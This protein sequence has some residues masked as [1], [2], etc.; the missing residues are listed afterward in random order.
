M[1]E[2]DELVVMECCNSAAAGLLSRLTVPVRH[3]SGPHAGKSAK[4][5]EAIR[6]A[7]GELILITD[8]DCRVPPDWVD[9]MAQPFAN[10]AVGVTFGPA[11]GISSAPGGSAG[12]VI[13]AGPA[14]PELW[15]YA[16]AAS[17][18]VRLLAVAD[19]GGF[20]ER[21]G[22]GSR[23]NGEEADL[24]LRLAAR[25]WTCEIAGSSFVQ[26]LERRSS[27]ETMRDLLVDRRG[28][29]TYLGAGLRR[30]PGRTM[31]P[32]I[33]RLRHEIGVWSDRRSHGLWLGPKILLALL[34]GLA[35]GAALPPQRF[36]DKPTAVLPGGDRPRVLWVTDEPPDRHL[37]GGNIRQAMLLAALHDRVDVT[38]LIVGHLRDEITRSALSEVIELARP[39][40]RPPPSIT[41]RRLRD[42]WQATAGR[43][44]SDVA[45]ARRLRRVLRP[46]LGRIADDFDVVVIQ[47]LYL[48]PLLPT[49]RRAQWLLH[50]FDVSSERTRHELADEGGCRQRWLLSREVAK[51]ARYER[52][53]VD[54]YDSV[55]VVS[56]Q[57][58]A[59]LAGNR[60]ANS[61]QLVIV[62]NG[63]DTSAF[64]PTPLP[65]EPRVLLPA[66]LSYRP[67][68][69]GARW[70]C[71]EVLPL[72]QSKVPEV[73]FNLVGRQPVPEVIALARRPGVELH[74][75]VPQ[76]APWLAQ[77]RVIVVP[78]RMGTGTR[79]KALEAMAAGR[80]V[81]G[82][83]IG[84]AGLG[85]IEGEHARVVDD[86]AAM[87]DAITELLVSDVGSALAA[88]ARRH[89]EE[90]YRWEVIGGRMVDVL[91]AS[92]GRLRNRY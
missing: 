73:Q 51:A 75:D 41:K 55:I 2:S 11:V 7:C 16:H 43:R 40:R 80:P 10:P 44:P 63:V 67:N 28:S 5:N 50:L 48:A 91:M 87:A 25:G 33:L 49:R 68:V 12:T 9:A 37:G 47:H 88:S 30:Q 61:R 26:H 83:S 70:F 82:T 84:L 22:S 23:L 20:D 60:L 13:P 46:V 14:P 58:A 52:K 31:K 69:L 53:V 76:M 34:A 65:R 24:V 17:M 90:H 79:L 62:P 36:L 15:N 77:A 18:A 86:P 39:R 6:S 21:L 42:T 8:D 54:S 64:R 45:H 59:A 27:E 19:A 57:D 78:L 71:D 38:L 32:L 74:A 4:L 1:A 72:V 81:V 35:R 56:N 66:T 29:G 89:V 92:T 3:V 85:I